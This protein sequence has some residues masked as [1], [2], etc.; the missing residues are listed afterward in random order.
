MALSKKI[1]W[2]EHS[3]AKMR[4]YGLSKSK[5]LKL[6]YKPD[7]KEEG[8]APQTTAVMA[9]NKVFNFARKE[10]KIKKVPGEI[11]LMY[12]DDKDIRKIISAWRYP[13][14]SKAGEDIPIPREI[15]EELKNEL[16]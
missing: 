15:V 10:V 1:F 11:W 3:K 8:I 12:K 5:L 16:K 13:G 2:T 4:Q 7:R 14:V 9:T 6:L